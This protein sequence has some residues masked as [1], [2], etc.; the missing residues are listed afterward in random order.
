MAY[1]PGGVWLIAQEVAWE[2]VALPP[3]EGAGDPL[4]GHHQA[5]PEVVVVRIQGV[6]VGVGNVAVVVE[7]VVALGGRHHLVAGEAHV[8]VR[9]VVVGPEIGGGLVAGVLGA[10]PGAD[11]AADDLAG[12]PEAGPGGVL[13]E[14]GH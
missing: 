14:A 1:C 13:E 9:V 8:G 10:D 2:G 11:P 7:E 5:C 6:V 12:D 3:S 4:V